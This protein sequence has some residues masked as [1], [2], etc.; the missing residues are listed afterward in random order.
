MV[1]A[2]TSKE[3]EV[4]VAMPTGDPIEPIPENAAAGQS[5]IVNGITS[6]DEE[7]NVAMPT[8]E[9]PE[10]DYLRRALCGGILCFKCVLGDN[11]T[12]QGE[13]GNPTELSILRAA[14]FGDLNVSEN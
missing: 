12:R 6:T 3:E 13:I 8:G 2:I 7:V 5:T 4:N 9:S 11:G 10:S 1:D 14:Y